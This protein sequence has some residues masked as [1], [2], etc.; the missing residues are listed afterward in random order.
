MPDS[1]AKKPVT[2]TRDELYAQVWTT[3][4][5]R[6]AAQYGVSGN[7]L[8]KICGRLH[9]PYP[10][11][12][13]WAR[14]AAGK[15]V[16]QVPLPAIRQGTSAQATISPSLPAPPPP[17]TPPELLEALTV[18][19]RLTAGL[20][21]PG[22]LTHP[23]RVV[24]G[25]IDERQRWREQAKQTSWDRGEY[26]PPDFTAM[27]RRRHRLLSALFI[28]LERHGYTAKVDERGRPTVELERLPVVLTIK[29]KYRQVRRL[30]TEEEAKRSSNPKRPW[31]REMQPTGLLQL[32]IEPR[33]HPALA[34]SWI[35]TPDQS[36]ERQLPEIA[37]VFVTAVP[38]LQERRRQLEEDAQRRREEE[39]QRYQE[40]QEQLRERNRLQG[41][42]ELASRWKQAQDARLFLQALAARAAGEATG[43][44][45]DRTM[46]EW[47]AWT[48]ERLVE[49]DPLEAGAGA[50]FQAIAAIDQ[51]TYREDPR[52][53]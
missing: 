28:A 3:P 2:L 53:R 48:R 32:S 52:L 1:K 27:E 18:A 47:I 43:P 8:A 26:M 15:K 46:D 20:K 13:Y 31:R 39:M 49:H 22:K 45:G 4:I 34:Q 17:Q 37:A 41:F 42:L 24:A 50:I 29:E 38:I 23:H 35:D 36:L 9:V 19:R 10:P 12:G 7:G 44:V 5:S 16:T 6:L 51:W 14:K 33:L 11:R 40:R 25:W 21:V 30:L